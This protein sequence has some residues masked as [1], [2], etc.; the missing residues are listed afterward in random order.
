MD[1]SMSILMSMCR[2]NYGADLNPVKVNFIHSRPT[3]ARDYNSYF[4]APVKFNADYDGFTLPADAV[5]RRLPI[6]NPQ[7][8]KIHDQ[9]I[10]RYLAGLDENN[11][12]QRVKGAIIDMLPSGGVSY[13]KVAQKLNMSTRTLQRKLQIGHSTY[14]TLLEEVRQEIAEGYIHDSTVNL[15]EIAFVLGYSEYSSFS[16]AYKRWT[17]IS[18]SQIR[19]IERNIYEVA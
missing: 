8:A 3:C 12:V 1:L 15:M 11:I 5:D 10:I 6:G 19:K 13:E 2:L 14:R 7:L 9:Y 18:P 16:R 4:K 17:K